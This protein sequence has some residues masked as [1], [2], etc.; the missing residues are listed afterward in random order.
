M[1]RAILSARI[2]AVIAEDINNYVSKPENQYFS[3]F[4]LVKVYIDCRI[5]YLNQLLQSN[6]FAFQ[7]PYLIWTS[8]IDILKTSTCETLHLN[9]KRLDSTSWKNYLIKRHRIK[10]IIKTQSK[11]DIAA[12]LRYGVKLSSET[13]R[14]EWLA[15]QQKSFFN[16]KFIISRLCK[17]HLQKLYKSVP[18]LFPAAIQEIVIQYYDVNFKNNLII[19]I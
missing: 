9:I 11:G 5:I 18:F 4:N 17:T 6:I 1:S 8:N 10:Y 19:K 15:S 7:L 13:R 3:N 14:N 12:F 16:R 2:W